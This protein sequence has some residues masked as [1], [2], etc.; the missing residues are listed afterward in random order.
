MTTA[1][2]TSAGESVNTSGTKASWVA[3]VNPNG[4]S[5][6]TRMATIRT[7]RL[8]SAPVEGRP[9]GG[10]SHHSPADG[11]D[12]AAAGHGGYGELASGHLGP[13]AL[14]STGQQLLFLKARVSGHAGD[15]GRDG[16]LP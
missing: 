16:P 14:A 3:T 13:R 6:D 9:S 1:I 4:V 11:D 5:N 2:G 7:S 15:I 10:R 12:E 8:H